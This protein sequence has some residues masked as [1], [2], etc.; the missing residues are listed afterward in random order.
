MI[1]KKTAA[2]PASPAVN[3][4]ADEFYTSGYT[5]TEG[6]YVWKD[7][8]IVMHE[9]FSEKKGAAR[10]GVKITMALLSDPEKDV[11]QFW[12][13]GSKAHLSFMPTDDGKGVQLVPE[14][15]ARTLS[16]ATNWNMLRES[17]KN[18]GVPEEVFASPSVEGLEGLWVHMMTVPEPA[19]RANMQNDISEVGQAPRKPGVV[20]VVSGIVEG[21]APWE[22]GGGMPDAK[23]AKKKTATPA[24]LATKKKAA[25]VVEEEPEAEAGTEDEDEVE[26]AALS[27]I[28]KALTKSPGGTNIVNLKRETFRAVKASHGDE[29][30]Q[31]VMSQIMSDEDRLSSVLSFS[32]WKLSGADIK[33]I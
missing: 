16:G 11:Q 24:A 29:M 27:G 13:F 17:L 10:L 31:Q 15:V 3:F 1:G 12:S 23:T 20:A 19:E 5:L 4:W 9:G 6:D 26:S 25:P 18:A 8:S 30:A 21:G 33:K 14:P 7:V 32:G 28:T 2:A 22:G